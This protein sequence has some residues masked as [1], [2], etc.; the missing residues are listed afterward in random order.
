MLLVRDNAELK[1]DN[2]KLAKVANL[3]KEITVK[4]ENAA[5]VN[6]EL[7]SKVT[8]LKAEKE[9]ETAKLMQEIERIVE[10]K[11]KLVEENLRF[12]GSNLDDLPL[13]ELRALELEIRSIHQNI[14]RA[15]VSPYIFIQLLSHST[16]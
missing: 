11:S 1:S 5:K 10:E 2:Q 12:L 4:L 8:E 9:E 3:N 14:Q 15:K 13:E 7:T 16:I 6:K